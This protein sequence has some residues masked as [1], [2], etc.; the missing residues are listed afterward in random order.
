MEI[1]ELTVIGHHVLQ[2]LAR[3]PIT[4]QNY[5]KNKENLNEKYIYHT[6]QSY[7]YTHIK[8]GIKYSHWPEWI[9]TEFG[10]HFNYRSPFV[11]NM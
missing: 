11:S 5:Q 3:W 2:L 8:E 4:A 7:K 6:F 10:I 1:T 9:I